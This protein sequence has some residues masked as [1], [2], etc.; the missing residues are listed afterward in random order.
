MMRERQVPTCGVEVKAP[1]LLG[2]IEGRAEREGEIIKLRAALKCPRP[3]LAR[4]KHDQRRTEQPF[5]SN[6]AGDMILD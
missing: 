4:F 6:S 1:G 3:C 2:L 5:C